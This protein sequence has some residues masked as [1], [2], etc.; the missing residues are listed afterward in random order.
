MAIYHGK[1]RK[2]SID[3][4]SLMDYNIKIPPCQRDLMKPHV[5]EIILSQKEHFKKYN[6]YLII[7]CL[8]LCHLIDDNK[9]TLYCIDGQ[10]RYDAFYNLYNDDVTNNFFIDIEIIECKDEEE[11]NYFF[12]IVNMNKPLPEFIKNYKPK[13][14]HD[15]KNYLLQ[16]YPQY[17]KSTEKP[18]KPNININKFLDEIQL[19]YQNI[20]DKMST[21]N[22]LIEW[23]ENLN[24][25][26]GEFLRTRNDDIIKSI[27][28]KIDNTEGRLRNSPKFYLGSYWLE[29]IPK[30]ISLALRKKVWLDFFN[31]LP[32]KEDQE[33]LCPCC[34]INFIGPHEF[35]CGHII[36][37]KNGGETC[38]SNLKPI[39]NLCNL[40]MGAMNWDDFKKTQL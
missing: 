25:E 3:M 11:M 2:L 18:Q 29:T 16:K 26:H 14:G 39:C 34:E 33:V 28:L 20:I 22:E 35:H 9:Y 15:L 21:T 1:T 5:D 36:S 8:N 19:R 37:S 12:K 17:I 40:S 27:L 32:D 6:T 10:H 4:K 38:L 30:K 13:I 24:K 7:G 31:S 23:F